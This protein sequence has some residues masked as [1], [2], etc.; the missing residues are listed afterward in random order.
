MIHTFSGETIRFDLIY[1]KRTS[2]GINIDFMEMLKCKHLKGHLKNAYFNYLRNTGISS[3]KG[4]K[5]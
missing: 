5:K 2:M 1:K 4:Q 3:N